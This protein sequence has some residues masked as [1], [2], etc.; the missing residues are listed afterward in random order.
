MS[1]NNLNIVLIKTLHP[2]N[3]G[4]TAR[5]MKTMGF[6]NLSLVAPSYFPS[7]TANAMASRATDILEQAS[8]HETLLDAVQDSQLIFGTSSRE[9]VFDWPILNLREA[10]L[11]AA[12]EA[13]SNNKV[14][15]IF[16]T[17]STGMT[18]DELKLC[19]YHVYIPANP[20]FSSLNLA[21][22]VQVACYE[23]M[24]AFNEVPTPKPAER[25]P[26][27]YENLERFYEHLESIAERVE[28]LK[29]PHGEVMKLKLRRL[30]Q[31]AQ[32]DESEVTTLRGILRNIERK[33]NML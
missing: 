2:A 13:K 19:H 20:E 30:F 14:S 26:S 27:P 28:F 33:L 29:G 10:S 17:E 3:I 31:R 32:L 4:S 18:N 23:L 24:M 5:A 22:A 1:S 6:S 21:Q 16:G 25:I 11:L 9:R 12:K 7:P 15:F 8:V